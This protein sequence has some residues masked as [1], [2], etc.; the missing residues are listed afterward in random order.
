MKNIMKKLDYYME[1]M[2]EVS[3]FLSLI[4]SFYMFI[5]VLFFGYKAFLFSSWQFPMLLALCLD[6]MYKF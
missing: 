1:R 2:L 5:R 4:L 3:L 6:A